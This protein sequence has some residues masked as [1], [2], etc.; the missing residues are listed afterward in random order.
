MRRTRLNIV[1]RRRGGKREKD[2]RKKRLSGRSFDSIGLSK[3]VLPQKEFRTKV[4]EES[5]IN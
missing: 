3:Y 4:L 5:R 2:K 1:R